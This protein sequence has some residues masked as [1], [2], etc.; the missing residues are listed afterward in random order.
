MKLHDYLERYMKTVGI[1]KKYF[2]R[3]NLKKSSVFW[4]S[5]A[6]VLAL[7]VAFQNCGGQLKRSQLFPSQ[8]THSADGQSAQGCTLAGNVSMFNPYLPDAT[9][10]LWDNATVMNFSSY[11]PPGAGPRLFSELH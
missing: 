4:A 7:G 3:K 9:Q 2:L 1:I 10:P 6:A 8:L 5:I 11:Q